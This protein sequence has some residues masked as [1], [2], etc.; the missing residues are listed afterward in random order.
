VTS[1]IVSLDEY[2]R[3]N[4]A[5]RG[6]AVRGFTAS[7]KKKA[8]K[9]G[10]TARAEARSVKLTDESWE[11]WGF[12]CSQMKLTYDQSI[13]F[14][15]KHHPVELRIPRGIRVKPAGPEARP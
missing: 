10:E 5:G 9:T 14:L 11:A 2:R 6:A 4:M 8:P 1:K 3:R 13:S 15:L 7:P 12:W